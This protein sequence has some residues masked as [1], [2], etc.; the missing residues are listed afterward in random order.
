MRRKVERIVKE[1]EAVAKIE[2]IRRIG[3]KNGEKR[4]ML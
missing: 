2:G 4:K 3:R 1:T